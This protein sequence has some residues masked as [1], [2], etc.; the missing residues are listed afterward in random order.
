MNKIAVVGSMAFDSIETPYGKA[1]NVVGGAATYF[2]ISA[3]FF[4]PVAMVAVVGEDFPM[5]ELEFLKARGIDI[6]GVEI[7]KGGRTFRWSGRYHEN[8]NLRDTLDLQLNVFADFSP[9]L[10][11]TYGNSDY[12]FLA[13]IHPSLQLGVLGQFDEPRLVGADTMNYWI[14][15]TRPELEELLRKVEILTIN[16]EEAGQLSGQRNVVLAAR[17]I[18]SMGPKHVIIKRGE[19]GALHFSADSI[20]AVPAYPLENVVD[21]TGAGDT[22]AGGMMGALASTPSNPPTGQQIRSAIAYGTVMASFV[23]EDFG[24][25]R[26]RSLTRDEIDHRYRQFVALTQI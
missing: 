20:F 24:F 25:R 14:E 5:S 19:Y 17:K 3:S 26:L 13:N 23:V 15:T 1:E 9:K 22:F 12:C 6:A 2:A 21:P 11:D 10:P 8:M 18:I 4:A 16:D 7:A